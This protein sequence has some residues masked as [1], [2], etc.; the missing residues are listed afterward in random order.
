M[1]LPGGQ[2]R[3]QKK[4]GQV[5]NAVQTLEDVKVIFGSILLESTEIQAP[6]Y[7]IVVAYAN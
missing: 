6:W 4:C 2:G 1:S 3:Y 5:Q 7:Q